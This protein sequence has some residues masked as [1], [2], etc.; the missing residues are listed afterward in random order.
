MMG[1]Y[2]MKVVRDGGLAA[3]MIGLGATNSLQNQVLNVLAIVCGAGAALCAATRVPLVL[4]ELN[5]FKQVAF[6]RG[7][8][9]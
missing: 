6:R 5:G 3:V 1:R 9:A 8:S 2:T 4:G 7:V